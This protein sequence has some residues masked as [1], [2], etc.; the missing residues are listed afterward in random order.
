MNVYI[1]GEKAAEKVING[2]PKNNSYYLWLGAAR[3]WDFRSFMGKMDMLR[4]YSK[5]FTEQEVRCLY[6]NEKGK[7]E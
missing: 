1:N 7:D 2:D 5:S 4:I 6:E 3:W